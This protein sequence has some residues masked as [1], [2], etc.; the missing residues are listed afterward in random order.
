MSGN[1]IYVGKKSWTVSIQVLLKRGF[2]DFQSQVGINE[3]DI[4]MS[5]VSD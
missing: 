1:I 5:I 4:S 2:P 3:V